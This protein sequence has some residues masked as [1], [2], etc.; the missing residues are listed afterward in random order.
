MNKRVVLFFVLLVSAAGLLVGCGA[1]SQIEDYIESRYSFVDVIT[2]N[3]D[4]AETYVYL[5]EDQQVQ[6]V[7]NELIQ[8]QEPDETGKYVNGRQVLIYDDQFVIMTENPDNQNQTLIE[9]SDQEFVRNHY[10]P[11]FF[12]GMLLGHMLTNMFG[13]GWDSSQRNRCGSAYNNDCYG[14]YGASGGSVSGSSG[15]GSLFRGGGPG[16]GK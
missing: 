3:Y 6:E 13:G 14:G 2:S 8:V 16:S 12:Q 11:G 10:N 5:A 1:A 4:S 9:L 15:R 7:A